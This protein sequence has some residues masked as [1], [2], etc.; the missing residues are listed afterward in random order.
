VIGGFNTGLPFED[1]ADNTFYCVNDFNNLLSIP[2]IDSWRSR[3]K[4]KKEFSWYSNSGAGFRIDHILSTPA[5]D[6]AIQS[7]GYDHNPRIKK[8]TDHSLVFFSI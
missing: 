3:N 1:E 5:M 6:Q 4:D 8:A 7:I 2:L